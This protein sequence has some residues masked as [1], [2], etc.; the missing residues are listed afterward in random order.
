M[1]RGTDERGGRLWLV[2]HGG[3]DQDAIIIQ[4]IAQRKCVKPALWRGV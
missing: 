4:Q 2:Q 1:K 3:L